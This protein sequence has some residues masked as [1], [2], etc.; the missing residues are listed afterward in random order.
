MW[1]YCHTFIIILPYISHTTV[2]L[3]SYY[4]HTF[5]TLLKTFSHNTATVS[6]LNWPEPR[7]CSPCLM[8]PQRM[9]DAHRGACCPP[10]YCHNICIFFHTKL[11]GKFPIL[12]R[13]I[14]KLLLGSNCLA[15][16]PFIVLV[17]DWGD[18]PGF[19]AN[20]RAGGQPQTKLMYKDV[21]S[22]QLNLPLPNTL[23]KQKR[24]QAGAD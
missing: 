16:W 19:V 4:C 21:S 1:H 22:S 20:L 24:K 14:Y 6:L 9:T 5:D 10:A 2:T 18:R 13:A 11:G 12:W 3:L 17:G 23:H 8:A 7:A 15:V